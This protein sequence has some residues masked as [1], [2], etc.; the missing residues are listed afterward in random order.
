MSGLVTGKIVLCIVFLE[1]SLKALH[2]QNVF[3]VIVESEQ[4]PFNMAIEKGEPV[5]ECSPEHMCMGTARLKKN[6]ETEEEGKKNRINAEKSTADTK[7][8]SLIQSLCGV[9]S[10]Q[11]LTTVSLIVEVL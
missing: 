7:K 5:H 8:I 2:V 6:N 3:T 10:H 11:S 1:F 4:V 9:L